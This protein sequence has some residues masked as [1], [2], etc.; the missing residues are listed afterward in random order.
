MSEEI[1]WK[2]ATEL[3]ADYAAKRLSPVEV[4]QAL[5]DRIEKL[6][7]TL[8]CF[9]VIDPETTLAQARASETRWMKNAPQGRID[10]VPVAVKD[11]LL[12]K[13][14]PTLRGSLT[15]DP[16]QPWDDDAPCVARVREHGGVLIGK[17]TTPEFG[18]KG[19]TD[20]PREGITRNPWNTEKTPGGS[21]GGSSAALAAGLCPLAFGTDGGGSI[22][23]PASFTGTF[24]HK[25][26]FGRVPAWPLSPFGTVAHVG[27][28]T[29]TVADAALFLRVMAEPDPRDWYALPWQPEDYTV[30]LDAGVKGKRIAWSPTL[31]G[32]RVDP[33]VARLCEQGARVFADLG[34]IVEEA[35]PPMATDD[36]DRAFQALWWGGAVF[37]LGA[38]PEEKKALLDPNLRQ[39]VEDG[40]GL[41]L[42]DFQNATRL[43]E[44]LGTAMNL[45]MRNYDFL[46]TPATAIA[47][48]DVG[49][50]APKDREGK[51][52]MRW[53]P[54]SY[55]FN[56][57]QNPA[58]SINCGFTADGLP[59]G[60]QIVGRRH[61]DH[62]VLIASLAYEIANPLYT[63]HPELD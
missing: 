7:P 50:V 35:E 54:F 32:S 38:L 29:R 13:G 34:A 17:T 4:A 51:Q 25:P 24:G 31:G 61:A 26:T 44:Q 62:D 15:I 37:L 55:P 46:L 63:K 42:R 52:W 47:A 16:D 28:M 1:A 48:F 9:N 45:F 12:T 58:A 5:L 40:S 21:S 10:G 14:W 33:E 30:N 3:L 27:P 11:L 19:S 41:T 53:T 22:R 20:N 57:T 39:V 2:P 56:L 8:N 6:N 36:V 60:L 18:W 49:V 23:I 43:R 59:V